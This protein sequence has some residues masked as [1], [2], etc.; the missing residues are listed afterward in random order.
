LLEYLIFGGEF[1]LLIKFSLL[2]KSWNNLFTQQTIASF[3]NSKNLWKKNTGDS[4]S[5]IFEEIFEDSNNC[6]PNMK[7]VV[8][9]CNI[10]A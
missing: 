8:S 5:G 9:W 10:Y 4:R 6:L 1:S 7:I 2:R 3:A